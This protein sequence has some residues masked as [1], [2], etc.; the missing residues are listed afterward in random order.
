MCLKYICQYI[1]FI[2]KI[3][4]I[5]DKLVK[6]R[7]KLSYPLIIHETNYIDDTIYR[8]ISMIINKNVDEI[9]VDYYEYTI[10][11]PL[12]K[13]RESNLCLAAPAYN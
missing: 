6:L 10:E 8:I 3:D 1:V 12:P 9:K 13:P 5:R 7:D 4:D 11:F 2:N